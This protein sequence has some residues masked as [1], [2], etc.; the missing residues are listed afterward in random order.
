MSTAEINP[1]RKH[2][3]TDAG[4]AQLPE[5]TYAERVRTLVSLCYHRDSLHRLSQAVRISVRFAH[6]LFDRRDGTTYLSHQ[7]YGHAYPEYSS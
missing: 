3:Y 5:P 7:Q 6:A 1:S 4:A 2:A